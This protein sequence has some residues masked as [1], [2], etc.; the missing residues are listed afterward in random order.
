MNAVRLNDLQRQ[1]AA[2]W[3]PPM[4][5]GASAWIVFMILGQTPVLRASGLALVILALGLILRPM[6][7]ALTVIGGLALAF[8]PAFWAQTGGAEMLEPLEV[9]AALVIAGAAA[10][11]VI[12]LSRKPQVGIAIAVLIFGGLFLVVVGTP[13]S[14]RLTTLLT[15]W[16][17]YLLIDGLFAANP[18]PDSPPTGQL[19]FQHTYGLLILMVIGI[20]ND[21]L[22]AL[23]APA[24]LLGLFLTGKRLPVWYW[25]V[26]VGISIFGLRGIILLYADSNWWSYPVALAEQQG[27]TVPFILSGGWRDPARWL[28]LIQLVIY[29]FTWFGLALGVIGLARLARWYPPV[30]VVTMIAYASYALF[31][32]VYFGADASVLLMPLLMIQVIWMTYAVY[33]FGQ[34][35]Q[36][37]VRQPD[38]YLRWLAPAGFTLLPIFMLLRI[39][40][41]V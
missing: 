14:L 37:G 17:L 39:A 28:D 19:G 2:Y 10:L 41:V 35:I 22:F 7:S 21:P 16:L 23:L 29:Q 13:R 40:G 30:G 12:L 33:T 8:C 34:W 36:K 24:V 15:A 38:S 11:V 9:I 4:A 5:A 26:L 31:G 20:L 25:I 32:L 18:R 1:Q 27:I 3:I 6:G